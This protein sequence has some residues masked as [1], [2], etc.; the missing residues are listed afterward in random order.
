[1]ATNAMFFKCAC[2]VLFSAWVA[3]ADTGVWNVQSGGAWS[4]P[5]NWLNGGVAGGSGATAYFTNAPDS[6]VTRPVV[7]VDTNL[8]LNGLFN[9]MGDGSAFTFAPVQIPDGSSFCSVGIGTNDFSV[10]S[11]RPVAWKTTLEGSG[12]VKL[13][14]LGL[15]AFGKNQTFTGP[16]YLVNRSAYK[17]ISYQ[18]FADSTN[19]VTGDLLASEELNIDYST[20]KVSGRYPRAASTG[21][22]W[23]LCAGAAHIKL[24]EAGTNTETF[25]SP[26]QAVT[27]AHIQEGTYVAFFQTDSTVVLSQPVMDDFTGSVTQTLSF[28][29]APRW[30]TVQQV[31]K[32][33][34]Q[35]S[36][37]SAV[38]GV[39]LQPLIASGYGSNTVTLHAGELSGTRPVLVSIDSGSGGWDGRLRVDRAE[40]FQQTVTLTNTAALVLGDQR[41]I[42][43][44]PASAAA[45]W[46]DASDETSLT[47]DGAGNI[48]RWDDTRGGGY[49]YAAAWLAAPV[50]L[51]NALNGLPAVDFGAQGSTRC[52]QWSAE[53]AGVQTIFWVIGSQAGGGSL[54]GRKP[55][56]TAGS[57]IRG[58]DA[59]K[60]GAA[61][62]GRENGLIGINEATGENLW[63]NGQLVTMSGA[64]LSGDYDMVAATIGGVRNFKASAFGRV[65][66]QPDRYQGGQRLCEV[67]V[68]TNALTTQQV[69]DTQAYLYKKWFG[70]DMLGYGAGKIDFLVTASGANARLGQAGAQPVE[71]RFVTHGGNL[72][73]MAG[74]TVALKA[75]EDLRKLTLENGAKVVLK[76]RKIHSAPALNGNILWLDASREEDFT[77]GGGAAVN[78]WRNRGGG[79]VQAV[80]PGT[81]K[82]TRAQDA[83][84]RWTVDL[85]ARDA[86]CCLMTLSNLMARSA[87]VVWLCKTNGALPLGSLKKDYAGHAEFR[88]SD[89][90]RNGGAA[91]L[92]GAV[93][94]ST[95]GAW[96]LDGLPI[97]ATATPIPT[98]RLMLTSA[99]M[100]G[101]GGRVSALGGNNFD[102]TSATYLYSGG[103]QLAEVLLYDITLTEDERRDVEA[104]LT[105]KWFGRRLPGY[106]D[107]AGA[108]DVPELAVSGASEVE[109]QGN[110]VL[111]IA[112]ATGSGT[113]TVGGDMPA[114]VT[115][116]ANPNALA[117]MLPAVPVGVRVS[118]ESGGSAPAIPAPGAAVR[119]DASV[120][121]SITLYSG[122]YAQY[123]EDQIGGVKAQ[124]AA[125]VTSW[126]PIY[127]TNAANGL[128]VI[129]FEWRGRQRAFKWSPRLTN[130]RTVFWMFKDKG[131]AQGGGWLLGDTTKVSDF[132]RGSWGTLYGNSA[133][134]DSSLASAAVRNGTVFIDGERRSAATVPKWNYQVASLVTAGDAAADMIAGDRANTANWSGM[135]VGEVIIYTNTLSDAA[136]EATEDYLMNKWLGRRS[137]RA[138]CADTQSVVVAYGTIPL[139][140]TNVEGGGIVTAL[141]GDGEVVTDAATVTVLSDAETFSGRVVLKNSSRVT[142]AAERFA[143]S[144]WIVEAGSVLDLGGQTVTVAG[145]GG[146]GCVSNGT[147]VVTGRI[148][149][150][151]DGQPGTLT[152][153]GDLVL[154]DGAE[155]VARY[156]RPLCGKLDVKGKLT[157]AGSGTV[158]LKEPVELGQGFAEPLIAYGGIVG[159]D[160]LLTH[161]VCT[162]DYSAKTFDFCL[163]EP[164]PGTGNVVLLTGFAGGTLLMLK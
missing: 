138:A 153:A 121:S 112:K 82:P 103:M 80:T 141:R 18:S 66:G 1:M 75:D 111:K 90:Q 21:K 150:G 94:T 160:R 125:G 152:V 17:G 29:A 64:G 145:I 155:I 10:Y 122:T 163:A 65:D 28:A 20:V 124:S 162:G 70:R 68:Y 106:A 120:A 127:K 136:C 101:W 133:L 102:N 140:V 154:A 92:N 51:T 8:L 36:E 104:Y 100:Q 86:G 61:Y 44:E 22:S 26:G 129:D 14:G 144:E 98:N 137:P 60:G 83:Q 132:I 78:A 105:W 109:V 13:S 4:D 2:V 46:V 43:S 15:F 35:S 49:P 139:R 24:L 67:L 148:T 161:W 5:A 16:L 73:V 91:M 11:G 48:T 72:A 130:I 56:G 95:Y 40:A 116:V 62:V 45:F 97:Q 126:I 128:P 63:V 9:W 25:L 19:Q 58:F 114:I 84:G 54:L 37:A 143:A 93:R 27:G 71:A 159:L 74:S 52:L 59:L 107:A 157:V 47:K 123:W 88:A 142:L 113:L 69:K 164:P 23:E 119:F 158:T 85:G 89:F 147:L 53:I 31:D 110:A 55:D 156:A 151:M 96:Y 108:C 30:E 33:V 76:A 149:L 39:Q 115:E 50:Y 12:A 32:L 3:R 81:V 42:P 7:M 87:F 38:S 6:S 118:R 135:E 34:S 41:S 57:F 131:S 77:F 79:S 134:F 117:V 99:V 146:D